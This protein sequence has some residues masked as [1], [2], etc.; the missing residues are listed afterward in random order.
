MGV[1]APVQ[2][3]DKPSMDNSDYS[4][5]QY[6][7]QPTTMQS[8]YRKN[9]GVSHKASVCAGAPVTVLTDKSKV[10]SWPTPMTTDAK[11]VPYMGKKGKPNLR[12]LGAAWACEG[13]RNPHLNPAWVAQLMGFPSD[14]LNGIEEDAK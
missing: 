11:D 12:L 14:Y 2:E 3:N 9:H 10:L 7:P 6:V 5:C 4:R 8:R 13:K 1:T